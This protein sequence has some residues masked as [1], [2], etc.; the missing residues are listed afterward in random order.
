MSIEPWI[1]GSGNSYRYEPDLDEFEMIVR[2]IRTTLEVDPAASSARVLRVGLNGDA[3][4]HFSTWT[5]DLVVAVICDENARRSEESLRSLLATLG[6]A[7]ESDLAA[8][9]ARDGLV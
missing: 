1:L 7:W 5:A 2:P 3:S 8:R 6:K 9:R 4:E